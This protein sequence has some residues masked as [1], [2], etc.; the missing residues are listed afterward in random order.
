M[1]SNGKHPRVSNFL[2]GPHASKKGLER[3]SRSFPPSPQTT[4]QEEQRGE[5]GAPQGPEKDEHPTAVSRRGRRLLL[6]V[7]PDPGRLSP[8]EGRGTPH[9]TSCSTFP[10]L[11]RS[12]TGVQRPETTLGMRMSSSASSPSRAAGLSLEAQENPLAEAPGLITDSGDGTQMWVF[13]KTWQVIPTCTRGHLRIGGP[14]GDN[15]NHV[16]FT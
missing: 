11:A 6:P 15:G 12:P 5:L 2:W 10:E 14:Y 1:F 7:I 16:L 8:R 3:N 13:Y 9:P 4:A